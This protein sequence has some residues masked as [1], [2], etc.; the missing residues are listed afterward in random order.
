M[1]VACILLSVLA[2]GYICM[3][4]KYHSTDVM[5]FVCSLTIHGHITFERLSSFF[6][7]KK[8]TA[9]LPGRERTLEYALLLNR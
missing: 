6:G 9:T 1:E 2:L 5:G 8:K 4:G 7:Q 3:M